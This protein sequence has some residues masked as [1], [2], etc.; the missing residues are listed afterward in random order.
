MSRGGFG[1]T[2]AA[3]ALREKVREIL[4]ASANAW[5]DGEQFSGPAVGGLEGLRRLRELRDEGLIIQ[6]RP[7]PLYGGRWQYRLVTDPSYVVDQLSLWGD[8]DDW[9]E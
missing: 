6:R 5:I 4:F 8:D 7:N 9:R 2:P 3:A 1:G